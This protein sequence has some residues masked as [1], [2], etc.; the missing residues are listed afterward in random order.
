LR[1]P[2]PGVT[3]SEQTTQKARSVKSVNNALNENKQLLL[4]VSTIA[5]PQAMDAIVAQFAGPG[6]P[7]RSRANEPIMVVDNNT[8]KRYDFNVKPLGRGEALVTCEVSVLDALLQPIDS[9]G[10]VD[11]SKNAVKGYGSFKCQ[12]K[13]AADGSAE[14]VD[15]SLSYLYKLDD[16]PVAFPQPLHSESVTGRNAHPA[17]K[18][19]FRAYVEKQFI[20]EN[21]D[22]I[23]AL[24]TWIDSPKKIE[25]T[26]ALLEKFFDPKSDSVLNLQASVL[27]T[28]NTA[29]KTHVHEKQADEG[30]FEALKTELLI[31][32]D[33]CQRLMN[34]NDLPRFRAAVKQGNYL[35]TPG[36]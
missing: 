17:L 18:A 31:A 29:F 16:W 30:D 3:A 13:V 19:E 22:F 28:V 24:Q 21:F 9:N 12:V 36:R 6:T 10:D 23:E 4:A 5:N 7:L 25:S 34:T 32:R 1:K 2:A 27:A 35:N 33:E 11:V 20:A 8:P 15:G 26:K 14:L